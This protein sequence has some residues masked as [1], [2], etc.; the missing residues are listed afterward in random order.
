M[1][2][3]GYNQDIIAYGFLAVAQ[4]ATLITAV[5][6]NRAA[7]TNSVKIDAARELAQD[8]NKKVNGHLTAMTGIVQ[9]LANKGPA[10]IVDK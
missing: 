9:T 3:G 5:I 10:V 8:T 2:S 6:N 1:F 4:I 7:R